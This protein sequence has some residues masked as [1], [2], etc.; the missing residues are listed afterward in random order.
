[1]TDQ[2]ITDKKEQA[3]VDA[4]DQALEIAKDKP[5][6]VNRTALKKAQRALDNYRKEKIKVEPSYKI[7]AMVEFLNEQGFRSSTSTAYDHRN[8]GKL[9]IGDDGT[10]SQSAAI[11]YAHKFLKLKS[12]LDPDHDD[13]LQQ[14]KLRK[15]ITRL[16]YDGKTREVKYNQLIGKLIERSQVEIEL[17]ERATNLKNY[18]DTIVRI[19]AGKMC[20]IVGGDPEKIPELKRFM[21]ETNRRAFDNYS[22]PIVGIEEE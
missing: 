4:L 7:P 11:A 19:E 20:K 14:E 13:S 6:G 2:K 21:L 12:G 22:R 17:A 15:D 16:D 8:D 9:P 10:I 18:L 1:M 3:L 5:I